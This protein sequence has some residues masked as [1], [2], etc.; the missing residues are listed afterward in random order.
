LAVV[1]A[2]R[3]DG[4]AHLRP[5]ALEPIEINDTP[6]TLKAPIGVWFSCF[7]TTSTP[8]RTLSSGQL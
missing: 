2:R 3:G 4:S 1:T 8:V 6:R 5:P 7:T